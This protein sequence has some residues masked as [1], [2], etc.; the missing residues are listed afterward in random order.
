M[1]KGILI[2]V[3][4]VVALAALGV[5]AMNLYVQSAG[6]QRRIERV[7][8][9]SLKVPVHV[10]STILT[11]W[12]GLK[13][14]GITV[15]QTLPRGGDFLAAE[16]FTARFGWLGLFKHRLDASSVSMDNPR[17]S[18]FQSP[19]G[20]W[21]LPGQ[22]EEAPAPPANPQ[23]MP[24]SAVSPAPAASVAPAP[25][26]P[27]I[28]P[29]APPAP[30]AV[31]KPP[32]AA[33]PW[34]VSV[35]SLMV[36]GAS[37]DFWDEKG[38]RLLQF[39]GVNLDCIDPKADGTK[40]KASCRNISLHDRFFLEN[41]QTDWSFAAGQLK[42]SSLQAAAAGGKIQADA[43]V[44][45]GAKHSP[46]AADARFDGV[47]V[48]ELLTDAGGPAGEVSGTMSGW[49]DLRG[50][51]GKTSSLNGSGSLTLAGG[52]MQGIGILQMLGRGLQIPD[53]VELNLKEGD[54]DWRMVNGVVKV[55]QLVLQSQNLQLS[56]QGDIG[57]DGKLKLDARLTIDGAVAEKLPPFI[58]EAFKPGGAPNSRFIDFQIGNTVSHPKTHLLENLLGHRIQ[59]QMSGL[60]QLFFNKKHENQEPAGPAP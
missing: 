3:V 5:L 38:N 51:S 15:A 49:I 6:T 22:S 34:E 57:T 52:R 14:S 9:A 18:W 55:D 47:N 11:P 53:L 58:L 4:A 30:V 33:H 45:T 19:G 27:A 32:A 46:F 39:S 2:A 7:L 8:S 29:P 23:S 20:R 25:P 43:Q 59:S 26:H 12:S 50:N 54:L 13:A 35:H 28:A 1:L 40:G 48:D 41:M 21:D 10:S 31:E 42:L 17:I 56:A 24:P 16:S 44:Q 37:F 60:M 36:N